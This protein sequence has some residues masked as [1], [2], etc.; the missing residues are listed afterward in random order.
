MLICHTFFSAI[1]TKV[2]KPLYL[3]LVCSKLAYCS[4]VW[5]PRLI[6]D[7]VSLK[8]IQR[9][10]SKYITNDFS[11]NYR[12]RLIA[13][14]LL[15]LMYRF[16]LLD[17]MFFIKCLKFPNPSFPVLDFVSLTNSNNTR[18]SSFSKLIH[19]SRRNRLPQH[20]YS[21]GLFA[22]GILYHA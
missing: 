6:K 14:Q 10:A 18:S 12:D 2:K 5:R 21:A 19:Q 13:I 8:R 4:Q 3:S 17:I 15:P 11:T 20:S 22:Y 7:I 16:E 1:P 9:R